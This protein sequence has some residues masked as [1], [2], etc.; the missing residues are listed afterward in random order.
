MNQESAN[1]IALLR[2]LAQRPAP[3][4]RCG[5]CAT[6]LSP[7]HRHL[8]QPETRRIECAC[9]A[10][11]LLFENQSGRYRLVPRDPRAL[12][13]FALDDLQWQ[14]LGVPIGLA[15][16]FHS[17]AAGKMMAFYPSPAGATEAQLD[18]DAWNEIA[19]LSV[20]LQQLQPDIE[21]LLVNRVSPPHLYLIAPIDRCYE[22]VGVVRKRWQGFSGG[23]ELQAELAA[24][25]DSLTPRLIN[26]ERA[27]A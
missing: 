18:L 3:Q 4:E 12:N 25:F 2:R 27:S 23:T 19:G 9:D 21:A 14:R 26:T 20:S 10:C 11:A 22:L 16:F 24:F 7:V 15:F 8:V 6:P 13:G 1:P 17:S 5:L